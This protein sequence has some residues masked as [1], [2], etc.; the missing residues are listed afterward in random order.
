MLNTTRDRCRGALIGTVL[1]DA[2]GRPFEGSEVGGTALLDE[3]I[4]ARVAAPRA[5]RYSDDGEMMLALGRSLAERGEIDEDHILGA[6]AAAHEPARGYGRGARAAFAVHA[7]GGS[8]LDA[9]RALWPEGSKGNGGA[10]RVAPVPVWFHDA[11]PADVATNAARSARATHLHED[12]TSAA[13][14]V[15]VAIHGA[16]RGSFTELSPDLDPYASAALRARLE[17]ARGLA[18]AKRGRAARALGCGVLAIDAV[19]AALWACAEGGTFEERL[20]RAISMGGDT[21]S[22][23][24][25]AGAVAGAAL[26]AA[27]IPT[28]WLGA[29]EAAVFTQIDALLD[30]APHGSKADDPPSAP[31]A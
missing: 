5:W 1:G 13:A 30:A 27:A 9:G 6:L 7:S 31:S 18:G 11:E 28:A 3:A 25:I 23:G 12:A 14:V 15:A 21:D 20:V 26:G 4:A 8:F 29:L 19:P 16:L 10:V 17:T 22:V 24:A 2:L